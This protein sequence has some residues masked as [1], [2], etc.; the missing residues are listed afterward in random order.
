[1]SRSIR[2]RSGPAGGAALVLVTLVAG[3]AGDD[4]ASPD[5]TVEAE[6][7][8]ALTNQGS[9]QME[10]VR[11]SEGGIANLMADALLIEGRPR[12]GAPIDIAFVQ[13]GAIRGGANSGPPTL[14]W[15]SE[16][17]R[18]GNRYGPGP[19]SRTDVEGWFPFVNDQVVMTLTGAQIK[20]ALEQGVSAYA[21]DAR[22]TF[23]AN[24]LGDRAG[25]FLHAAGLKYTVTCAGTTRIRVGPTDCD[26]VA[27]TCMYLNADAANSI[28]R[29][30]VAGLVIFDQTRGGWVGGGDTRTFRT[31]MN[32]F[33]AEGRDNHLDFAAGTDRIVIARA[34][35]PFQAALVEYVRRLSPIT[36]VEDDDRIVVVGEVGGLS[37]SLPATCTPPH[38]ATH[39]KC[40]HLR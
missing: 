6:I 4:A 20:R 14:A 40:A 11:T 12:T 26:P 36:L 37:C 23:G 13:G 24:L 1:M 33:I 34:D 38:L 15:S 10:D 16:T 17:A 28:T 8:G 30:E 18:I 19:L 3:C 25:G 39:P 21:D 32:S 9:T 31:I 35:W 2:H 5:A 29:I 27:G 7:I 22:T